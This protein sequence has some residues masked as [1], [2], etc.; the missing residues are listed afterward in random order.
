[1]I[2]GGYFSRGILCIIIGILYI[3]M[4]YLYYRYLKNNDVATPNNRDKQLIF[5]PNAI[6]GLEIAINTATFIMF[7][8]LALAYLLSWK[9][10]EKM[11]A[12]IAEAC[13]NKTSLLTDV[14]EY[15]QDKIN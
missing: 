7:G 1:M 11:S 6:I 12:V 10:D 9:Y 4:A 3:V 13:T 2:I 5:G 15:L 8:L 14:K